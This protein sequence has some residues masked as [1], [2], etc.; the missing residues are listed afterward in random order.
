MVELQNISVIFDD[1]VV[2]DN[3]SFVF[4]KGVNV[5][6]GKSGCGKTTLL[7]VVAGLVKY[8]G[9]VTAQDCSFVFQQPCLAPVSVWNNVVSVLDGNFDKS[10]VQDVLLRAEILDKR[11]QNAWTLS[12]GEQQRVS[13]A[14]AFVA[15]RQV[16]LLD[17]PFSN[18]DYGTKLQLRNV[19]VNLLSQGDKTV[20]LVTHDL[21]DVCALANNVYLVKDKPCAIAH[22]ATLDA[23]LNQRKEDDEQSIALKA[24]LRKLLV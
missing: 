19:L 7:N 8:K 12:G 4:P 3:F 18:L 24:T 1:N 21:D 10:L 22:V 15:Q 13:L 14:R 16:V 9:N 2:Y 5:L 20:L 23:P 6:V 17:E 11:N